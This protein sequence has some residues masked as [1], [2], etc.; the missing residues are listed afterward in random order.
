MKFS[1]KIYQIENIRGANSY[2]V[3]AAEGLMLVDAGILGNSDKIIRFI[4]ARG[5]KPEDLKYIVLTHS[6]IDHT[7]SA[8]GLKAKTGAKIAIHQADADVLAGRKAPKK[9]KG[10]LGV[11]YKVFAKFMQLMPVEPDI[12]LKDGDVI[13]GLT[14]IHTPGHTL[15]SISLFDRKNGI[16]FSG[17]ALLCDKSGNIIPPRPAFSLDI[18]Q[19]NQSA[20]KLRALNFKILLPGHGKPWIGGNAGNGKQNKPSRLKEISQ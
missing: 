4:E 13:G 19:A 11:I 18:R 8:D 7:G 14:V 9:I 15:G 1:D 20:E 5:K 3:E 6:D 2:L 17:D 12:L 16:L 10:F